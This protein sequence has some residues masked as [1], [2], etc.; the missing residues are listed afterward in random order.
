MLNLINGN[1]RKVPQSPEAET[2]WGG[3]FNLHI[4]RFIFCQSIL[5]AYAEPFS[6]FQFLDFSMQ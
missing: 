4:T 2:L 3:M 6:S 5:Q 1:T